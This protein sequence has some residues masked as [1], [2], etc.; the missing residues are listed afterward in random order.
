MKDVPVY[1]AKYTSF[2]CKKH[3]NGEEFWMV[4]NEILPDINGASF[5]AKAKKWKILGDYWE[6]SSFCSFVIRLYMESKTNRILCEVSRRSS[7]G[8]Y[9]FMNFYTHLVSRLPERYIVDGEAMVAWARERLVKVAITKTWYNQFDE[10]VDDIS[11]KHLVDMCTCE[12]QDVR[13]EGLAALSNF[14]R[15]QDLSPEICNLIIQILEKG[16]L[17]DNE[18]VVWTYLSEI[19]LNIGKANQNLLGNL[20]PAAKKALVSIHSE[21]HSYHL[22]KCRQNIGCVLSHIITE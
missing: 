5:E 19:L 7:E 8:G 13:R 20:T 2:Y 10:V 18:S 6:G 17:E 14:D 9:S 22:D 21:T 12:L 4:L 11:I 16:F 3:I 15:Y 1:V